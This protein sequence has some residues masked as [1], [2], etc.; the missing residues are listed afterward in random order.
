MKNLKLLLYLLLIPL[1]AV[2][3]VR[4]LAALA[5]EE[6][7]T[8]AAS[9]GSAG[10]QSYAADA[11]IQIGSIVRLTGAGA[12][13]VAVI[14]QSE[15]GNMYGVVVD[16]HQLPITV[17]NSSIQNET[18]VATAGTYNVLVSNQGGPI[19]SGDYVTLSSLSGVAMKAGT[20]ESMV[21][22]RAAAG[23]D[24]KSDTMGSLTLK[25]T[26]GQTNKTVTLGMVPVAIDVKR[27]PNKKSTKTN[28]PPVLQRLGQAVAEKPIGPMRIYLSIAITGI[29][30][31]AAIVI[32]YSGVRNSIISIGRNPLSKKSIFRGLLE[33]V[34]TSIIILIIGLF[35]VYLL[36]KL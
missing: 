19:K 2:L 1:L 16:P 7:S 28:L 21:F 9:N 25:D 18:Y 5:A 15:I 26:A 30:I 14:K 23:F 13:K 33:I 11:P 29:S 35:A 4:P 22:G 17:S 6:D 20:E 12:G 34:L 3:F 31:V 8:T 24:G 27:N 36:L 10:V 32:L